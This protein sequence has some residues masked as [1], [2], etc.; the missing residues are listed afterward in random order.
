MINVTIVVWLAL[1]ALLGLATRPA[2]EV[3]VTFERNA[4]ADATAAFKFKN[5]PPP[6]KDDAAAR[7]ALALVVG[8]RDAN[9]A[10]LSAL[11]DGALPSSEDE[12]RANFFFNAG[13]DGGRF[14]IDLG[15][16]VEIA[17]VNTYSW[18]ANTRGPQVYNLFASDG[19]APN[20][21]DA[22]DENT[23][24]RDCGWKL[25]TTVDTRPLRG[26]R[27]GQYGASVSDTSGSLGRYRYLL[28]D[29]VPTEYDDPFGNT[30]Y[31][32]VDVVTKN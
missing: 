8:R 4:G 25:I 20:F 15:R 3:K 29:S 24:P 32:E 21:K 28:F 7:A 16:A 13:T 1:A 2:R 17:Q 18:H 12:P 9:G 19:N 23:D 6:A 27:G 5:V 26:E 31:S 10:Q 11:T 30:F 14:R 22:P